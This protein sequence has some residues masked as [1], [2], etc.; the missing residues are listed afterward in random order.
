MN[1][2]LP[3]IM[4]THEQ[5]P[6]AFHGLSTERATLST[7]DYS[8]MCDVVNLRGVVAIER[9]SISDLL[10]CV[11]QQRPCLEREL[12][13]LAQIRFPALGIGASFRES[14]SGHAVLSADLAPSTRQR[15]GVD[16][17]I[18]CCAHFCRRPT[19]R[20]N[21][22]A[23]FAFTRRALCGAPR[24]QPMNSHA[25]CQAFCSKT[26]R[27]QKRHPAYKESVTGGVRNFGFGLDQDGPERGKV[28][29]HR[30]H[31]EVRPAPGYV[32]TPSRRQRRRYFE[33]SLTAP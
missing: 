14:R 28:Y 26:I 2:S 13:R 6:L 32:R 9:K 24:G 4:D 18:Q 27:D 12:S 33:V 21:R 23:N 19:R 8:C 15:S 16:L 3:I 10:G 29:E 30:A 25:T 1:I 31:R 11:G 22:N 5:A 17:Q 7:G 20:R